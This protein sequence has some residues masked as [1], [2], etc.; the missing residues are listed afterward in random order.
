MRD[1]WPTRVEFL[2][3]W[4][5]QRFRNALCLVVLHRMLAAV[6][7]VWKY[8]TSRAVDARQCTCEHRRNKEMSFLQL[9]PIGVI[10]REN[11]L[12]RQNKA[13]VAPLSCG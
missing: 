3:E 5:Q 9:Q 10:K 8:E 6:T 1:A 4:L 7:T 12:D 2:N 11:F 13:R